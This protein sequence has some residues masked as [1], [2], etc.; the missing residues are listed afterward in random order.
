MYDIADFTNIEK[1][2]RITSKLHRLVTDK[3]G[4]VTSDKVVQ[5]L[6]FT[7]DD[8]TVKSQ[9]HRFDTTADT[10]KDFDIPDG[11]TVTYVFT[12]DIVDKDADPDTGKPEATHD[13]LKDKDTNING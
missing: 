4:K 3:D 6:K 8:E 1:G 9:Q 10:T 11:S 7:A 5:I 12:E 13:D 2:D